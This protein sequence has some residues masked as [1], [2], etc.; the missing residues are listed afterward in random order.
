VTLASDIG[1]FGRDIAKNIRDFKDRVKLIRAD[2][3]R[4]VERGGLRERVGIDDLLEHRTRR[5][6]IDPMLR[7]LGWN[8][9]DP[10]QIT[11][12][13][14]SWDEEGE[15]LYFDYL[16]LNRQRAPVLMVEAKG[17]DADGPRR[18]RQEPPNGHDMAALI[19]EALRPL[20]HGERHNAV[21]KQW[22]DWLDTLRVYVRS[23]DLAEQATL[24]RVVITSGQ[25]LIVFTDPVATLATD[26]TPDAA[27]IRC[28]VSFED[29]EE[30]HSE[31]Y[32]LLARSRLVNTLP[33]TFDLPEALTVLEPVAVN[34]MFR[35]VLVTTQL[36]G[37]ER[38]RYPTRTVYPAVVLISGGRTFG[39]V[40]YE[41]E[42]LEEPR[43]AEHL[44]DFLAA[45]QI[46]GDA[47]QTRVLGRLGRTELTPATLTQYPISIREAAESDGLDP[48][49]S[50][51]AALVEA[52]TP[53]RPQLVRVAGNRPSDA[54]Y[55]VITG[56]EWFH[57]LLQPFGPDC[58]FHNFIEARKQGVSDA[59]PSMGGRPDSFTAATD[60]QHCEHVDIRGLRQ[61]I[62][63]VLPIETHLCCRACVFYGVC[64]PTADVQARLPCAAED[65]VAEPSGGAETASSD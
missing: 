15:T 32:R 9:A 16:G 7:A 36:S 23:L 41:G 49:P 3:T 31:L 34:L 39:V 60:L 37:A 8:V 46:R 25:W 5:H 33:L 21:V 28:F 24:K 42:P 43:K 63:Q 53:E 58:V 10:G 54:S 22:A 4:E 35:G 56:E 19:S 18:P 50:S 55:L 47:F 51:T 40:D 61:N 2:E 12:E 13:A 26:T 59:Q 1:V 52:I 30:R 57:K 6:V 11:E 65:G 44:P 17:V 62:C 20:K 48:L 27:D 29:L 38:S 64:W 45:L 14:R